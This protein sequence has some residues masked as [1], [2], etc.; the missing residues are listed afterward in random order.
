MVK[1]IV[2]FGSGFEYPS[3]DGLIDILLSK[4]KIRI[5]RGSMA[6]IRDSLS[7][8][9]CTIHL[10]LDEH[11]VIFLS[12]A[13]GSLC[14]K[15]GGYSWSKFEDEVSTALH[16]AILQVGPK[17]VVQVFCECDDHHISLL[18]HRLS[19]FSHLFISPHV[20]SSSLEFEPLLEEMIVSSYEYI[21]ELIN[22]VDGPLKQLSL[23]NSIKGLQL[24][25]F[26]KETI[27]KMVTS[28][29]W[30]DW[31]LTIMKGNMKIVSVEKDILDDNWW[32][33]LEL[34]LDSD[35]YW[36]CTCLKSSAIMGDFFG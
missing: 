19:E 30:K 25:F 23:P 32:A 3:I 10:F 26:L 34:I 16:D 27:V 36:E 9:G 12:S 21:W 4:D 20:D 8:T 31:K 11:Y 1:A 15:A 28:Q 17:N 14:L 5:E 2:A 18:E 22:Q 24:F 6:S 7:H 13:K 35:K 29:E 33:D